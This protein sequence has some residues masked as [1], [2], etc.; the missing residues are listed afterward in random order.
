[1]QHRGTFCV[2]SLWFPTVSSPSQQLRPFKGNKATHKTPPPNPSGQTSSPA[3]LQLFWLFRTL[4]QPFSAAQI[5]PHMLSATHL[6][7]ALLMPT[8]APAFLLSGHPCPLHTS[9]K[10]LLIPHCIQPTSRIAFS[11]PKHAIWNRD[12][13]RS[14]EI[15]A[16][17]SSICWYV[18]TC[19]K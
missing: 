17:S 11:M 6:N 9:K 13:N 8:R 4:H 10:K 3:C 19:S 15:V 5:F 18:F 14:A 16:S 2:P 12:G 7:A 1:M